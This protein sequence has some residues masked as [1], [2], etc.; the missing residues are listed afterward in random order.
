MSM[1]TR[2][3]AASVV[4]AALLASVASTALAQS[5]PGVVYTDYQAASANM[6][7]A[8]VEQQLVQLGVQ[9]VEPTYYAAA[10]ITVLL[11]SGLMEVDE[12]GKFDP[13]EE[14]KADEGVAVFAKVLGIASKEDSP[15]VALT[16]AREA[17]VVGGE[18]KA[19]EDLS[20]VEVARMLAKALGAQ[21][22]AVL[23]AADYPFADFDATSPEDRGILAALHKLGIF[24]GFEDKTFRPD[25]ILTKEQIAILIDRILGAK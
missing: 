10:S 24:K 22:L 9:D 25:G 19:D 7:V 11:Q 1:T 16:K 5:V 13:K 18:L 14:L 23:S 6:P 21:P 4:A 12:Q 15:E 8:K 2:K 20:R 17:G 3:L